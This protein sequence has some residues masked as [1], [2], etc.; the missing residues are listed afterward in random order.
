MPRL[1]LAVFSPLPP[2]ATGVADYL[3]D[4]LPA[5][6]DAADVDLFSDDYAQ[7]PSAVP[8]QCGVYPHQAFPAR[9]AEGRYDCA[10]Y[11]LGN[12][13]FHRYLY[14]YAVHYPGVAVLHDQVLHHLLAGMSEDG[15][16]G[17][18]FRE[19]AYNADTAGVNAAWEALMTHTE[20]PFYA[21][22]LNRRVLDTSLGIAVHSA[23]LRAAIEREAPAGLVAH[24]PMGMPLPP[25]PGAAADLRARFGLPQGRFIVGS[26]G[27]ATAQKR[28]PQ[29][30]QAVGNV[31]RQGLDIHYII[32]GNVAREL[33]LL[34][35]ADRLG[36][37]DRVTVTGYVSDDVFNAYLHAVDVC[38]NLRYPTAGETSAAALRCMAAGRPTIVTAVG[39][40]LEFANDAC[41]KAPAGEGEVAS[42][43]SAVR[44]LHDHPKA[45]QL[46][47]AGARAYV[48]REHSLQTAAATLLQFIERC[49]LTRSNGQP[50]ETFP[51]SPLLKEVAV[52]LNSMGITAQEA[53]LM[54]DLATAL[55]F[56]EGAASHSP[57]TPGASA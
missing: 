7:D 22:P 39:A 36:L 28:I 34:G 31:A 57:A 20:V 30:L 32:V 16:S 33:D 53:P 6:A 26:F 10:V 9:R 41:L 19:M 38:V 29:V 54:S 44:T 5:L 4:V 13:P 14:P 17:F 15:G 46:L 52:R 2:Q 55:M 35:D 51:A 42:L 27:Q 50:Q 1:R 25:D 47:G 8:P 12:S 49:L 11:H 24:I 37:R 56:V 40:S 18:Y 48:Q 23:Y 3:R 21:Y 43:E 45:A